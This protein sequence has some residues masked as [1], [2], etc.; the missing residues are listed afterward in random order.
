MASS[1]LVF[2]RQLVF[3][4]REIAPRIERTPLVLRFSQHR[5][6]SLWSDRA[7]RIERDDLSGSNVIVVIHLIG[8]CSGGGGGG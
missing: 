7:P 1:M 4:R 2:P 8:S 6:G 5:L 3:S